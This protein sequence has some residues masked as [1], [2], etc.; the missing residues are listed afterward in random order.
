MSDFLGSLTNN[1]KGDGHEHAYYEKFPSL[2][3]GITI[4]HTAEVFTH[5]FEEHIIDGSNFYRYLSRS[6]APET[7]KGIRKIVKGIS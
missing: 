2:G 5:A 4:G 6:M 7:V 1:A 3:D